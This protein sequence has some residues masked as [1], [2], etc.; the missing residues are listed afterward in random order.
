[1]LL[2]KCKGSWINLKGF[3]W[4]EKKTNINHQVYCRCVCT[5][6]YPNELQASIKKFHSHFCHFTKSISIL[7][8]SAIYF[9]IFISIVHKKKVWTYNFRNNIHLH[10]F[11]LV[12]CLL[13]PSFTK[14][15]WFYFSGAMSW[16]A[17]WK[18]SEEPTAFTFD[19]EESKDWPEM[20]HRF[21]SQEKVFFLLSLR[22][23]ID[24]KKHKEV[25]MLFRKIPQAIF[26]VSIIGQEKPS[27][28]NFNNIKYTF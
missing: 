11:R 17:C 25:G 20:V 7:P 9:C 1:M 22:G 15:Q 13:C 18:Q 23:E 5:K 12:Y 24:E 2:R 6:C 27:Y 21:L 26:C 28:T 16:D 4:P 14:R 19:F 8:M 10:N 3:E